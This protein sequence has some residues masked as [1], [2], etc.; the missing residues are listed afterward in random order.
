MRKSFVVWPH[1][2]AYNVTLHTPKRMNSLNGW[3]DLLHN[4][5]IVLVAYKEINFNVLQKRLPYPIPLPTAGSNLPTPSGN[6]AKAHR[7]LQPRH[8][9]PKHLWR[10]Y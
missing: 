6:T 7:Q 4:Q 8:F 3:I 2:V 10:A 1:S 5:G 9:L